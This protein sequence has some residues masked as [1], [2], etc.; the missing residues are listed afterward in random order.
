MCELTLKGH[1]YMYDYIDIK[2]VYRSMHTLIF[3]ARYFNSDLWL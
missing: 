2:V 3:K 1:T